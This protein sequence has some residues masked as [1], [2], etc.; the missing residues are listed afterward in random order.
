MRSLTIEAMTVV[1]AQG[2]CDALRGF[3]PE[4]TKDEDGVYR[5]KIVLGR[6]DQ[7]TVEVLNAVERH[8]TDRGADPARVELDGHQYTMHPRPPLA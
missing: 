4:L 8:L 2:L 6:G 5:V 3:K 7:D 1:S